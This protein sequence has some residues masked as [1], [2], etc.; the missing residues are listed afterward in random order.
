[1]RFVNVALHAASAALLFLV[2]AASTGARAPAAFA[3]A[4]FAIHPLRVESVVWIS[5]RKDVLCVFF[6]LLTVGAWIRYAR[7]PGATRYALVLAAFAGALMSKPM[8]VTLPILLLLLDVWPLGRTARGVKTLLVEKAPLLALSAACAVVTYVVQKEGGAMSLMGN[9]PVGVRLANA[10]VAAATYVG[11]T[12]LPAGLAVIYPYPPGGPGAAAV[13]IA[14]V[15]LAA[16]TG[17][18]IALRRRL[19]ALAWGWAWY[20]VALSPVLGFVQIGGQSHADRYTY[21]PGVGLAVAVAWAGAA[22]A[23]RSPGARRGVLAAAAAALVVL[24]AANVAQQRFWAS[25]AA[26]FGRAVAVTR[27]NYVA[28]HNLAI[29]L[30]RDGRFADAVPHH[31]EAIRAGIGYGDA[32]KFH[33]AYADTLVQL[34]RVDEAAAQYREVL[35]LEPGDARSMNDLAICLGRM[36]DLD[37]AI[38]TYEEAVRLHPDDAKFRE[39]LAAAREIRERVRAGRD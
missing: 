35:A 27:D 21:L 5:E 20:L 18:A 11:A 12:F 30:A 28:H 19:P 32:W 31:L 10:V 9:L 22:L 4:I 25:D 39:N 7:S 34:G 8:A 16:V 29:A 15:V 26:L 17:A 3:A 13:A 24:A 6:A 2:L 23:E 1:M 33:R 36:G 38:A 37:G 14:A